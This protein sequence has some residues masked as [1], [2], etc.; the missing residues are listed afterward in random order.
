[1]RAMTGERRSCSGYCADEAWNARR[2]GRALCVCRRDADVMAA[3]AG[4]DPGADRISRRRPRL[5]T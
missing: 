1:M 5:T 3:S 2:V 4:S